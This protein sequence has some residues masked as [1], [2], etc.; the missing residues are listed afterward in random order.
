MQMQNA[1]AVKLTVQL[2]CECLREQ[3]ELHWR[4]NLVLLQ[5][6][7]AIQEMQHLPGSEDHPLAGPPKL[8]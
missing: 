6:M 3:Q 7:K 1:P 2:G 5:E 4:K 8:G